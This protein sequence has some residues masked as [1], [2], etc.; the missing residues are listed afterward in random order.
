LRSQGPCWSCFLG[1][2]NV[3]E[4]KRARDQKRIEKLENEVRAQQGKLR[5]SFN[6]EVAGSIPAA[7]TNKIQ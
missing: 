5:L 6:Q 3:D 1:F 4:K 7:L 2:H